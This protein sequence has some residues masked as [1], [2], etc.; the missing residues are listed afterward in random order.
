[1]T[2]GLGLPPGIEHR[3][4]TVEIGDG[5]EVTHWLRCNQAGCYW[6]DLLAGQPDVDDLD[7][8]WSHYLDRRH[9]DTTTKETA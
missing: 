1:M 2:Q 4:T 3:V 8:A 7:N 6:A 5:Q 9:F